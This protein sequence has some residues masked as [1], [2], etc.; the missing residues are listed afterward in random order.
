[1]KKIMS[2]LLLVFGASFATPTYY[3]NTGNKS[4]EAVGP[5]GFSILVMDVLL[6]PLDTA[7]SRPFDLL[8][9]PVNY[10]DTG[11]GD[12]T[13]LYDQAMGNSILSCYDVSDSAAVTDSTDISFNIQ[14]SQYAGDN[15]NPNGTGESGGKSDAWANA[16]SVNINATSDAQTVNESAVQLVATTTPLDRFIRWRI[17]NNNT[18]IKDRSRCRIYWARKAINR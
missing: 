13:V 12:A 5:K 4:V 17:F 1:M 14:L 3:N 15:A 16:S 7:Y 8:N 2:L 10:R 6:Q 11:V 9:V 18:T